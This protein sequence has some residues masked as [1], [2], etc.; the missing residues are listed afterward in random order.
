MP[1]GGLDGPEPA[2]DSA[3]VF[4]P[5]DL[6]G[7][8]C[9]IDPAAEAVRTLPR[10][11][12][13]LE[14]VAVRFL[15]R[16]VAR[17]PAPVGPIADPVHIL[18]RAE[19]MELRRILEGAV[20]RAFFAGFASA[21]FV[22]SVA[23]WA[24]FHRFEERLA[25]VGAAG[26]LTAVCE[27]VYLHRQHLLAMLALMRATGAQLVE[28]SPD[29]SETT[30][31]WQGQLAGAMARAALDLPDPVGIVEGIDP[32]RE[33]SLARLYVLVALY[34]LKRGLSR[35]AAEFVVKQ[36]APNA[37]VRIL[38][39]Y[40]ALP[41]TAA[42]NVFV[43]WKILREA[44][45]RV[46]GPS[47]SEEVFSRILADTTRLSEAGRMC[48]YRAVGMGIVLKR[49]VHPNLL[50]LLEGLVRRLGPVPSAHLDDRGRFLEV[51]AM[52]SRE[53]QVR[54]LQVLAVATVIDGRLQGRER[55][56]IRQARRACGLSERLNA[57]D[58]LLSRFSRGDPIDADLLDDLAR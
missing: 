10:A 52:L 28:E 43:S 4:T 34:R 2:G 7:P 5:R 6:A 8:A 20:A 3:P 22:A 14:R 31:H 24:K 32:W 35:F 9:W 12:G 27:M 13:V 33:T 1:A 41:V 40:A 39:P 38:A 11:P 49:S 17:R 48:L 46:L 58:R 26:L 55:V 47:A 54:A 51:I 53:E 37:V 21:A 30:V 15:R 42:W 56:M 16:Q 45:I 23:L 44:R 57:V 29:P 18:T 19:R 36:A 25:Y 50:A